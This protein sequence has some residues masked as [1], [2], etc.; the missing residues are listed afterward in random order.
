MCQKK[1]GIGSQVKV[2][3]AKMT[4]PQISENTSW[5]EPPKPTCPVCGSLLQGYGK[6]LICSNLDCK[7]W[8]NFF[9]D[10]IFTHFETFMGKEWVDEFTTVNPYTLETLKKAIKIT[11][12]DLVGYLRKTENMFE[13]L[14][15]LRLNGKTY[16]EKRERVLTLLRESYDSYGETAKNL[17]YQ[18]GFTGSQ[19]DYMMILFVRFKAFL[20]RYKETK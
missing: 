14:K 20:V 12:F 7:F 15:P 11:E 18:G 5:K 1:L 6:D 4:I 3:L 2:I 16:D 19:Y 17:I 8:D 13:I 9:M 10:R